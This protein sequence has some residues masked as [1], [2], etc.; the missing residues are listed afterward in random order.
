[1]FSIANKGALLLILWS[2]IC[3]S[4]Q[5]KEVVVAQH[6][7][8]KQIITSN[9]LYDNHN[10]G[11]P[12]KKEEELP[13]FEVNYLPIN[14]KYADYAPSFFDDQ[15]VFASSRTKH[16]F[17]KIIDSSNNEPFLD[18]YTT[19]KT[20]GRVGV[21]KLKGSLNT[22][23][24]ESSAVFTKDGTEVYFTRNKTVKGSKR[25]NKKKKELLTIYRADFIKGE[26]KNIRELPFGGEDY[27]IAHPALSED[28]RIL[29]FVS[30][31]P[32]GY[33][34]SDLYS[35]QINKSTGYGVPQN[36]GDKINTSGRETF[37]FVSDKGNL[38]FASDGHVGHG[39]LDVFMKVTNR[40]GKDL[41]YNLGMP[42]NSAKDDFTFIINEQNKVGY[43][44]SNRGGGRGSD[45]IYGFKQLKPFPEI[46]TIESPNKGLKKLE[47]IINMKNHI[48]STTSL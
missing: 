10:K 26:W 47:R 45:D 25:K 37:P 33:G 24:H 19:Q 34:K 29:Y 9:V 2:Q 21:K 41:A 40:D 5:S 39:G 6:T 22:K 48:E 13:S 16:S 44:A 15:L 8:L 11:L 30:D 27:S 23:F 17:V 12:D 32:G 35:V 20:S 36:M 1:M 38:F 42:I 46:Y 43:F 4:Q 18:L 28:E 7:F 14:S 31:M 3:F